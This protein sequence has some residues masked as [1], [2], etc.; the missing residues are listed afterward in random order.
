M[1][2]SIQ[3]DI[4]KNIFKSNPIHITMSEYYYN[5]KIGLILTV[6]KYTS[7]HYVRT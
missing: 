5:Y 4:Y 2:V 1:Y 7:Y 3:S 6:I